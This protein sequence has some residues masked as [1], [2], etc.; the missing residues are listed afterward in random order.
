VFC[1]FAQMVV[2]GSDFDPGVGHADQRSLEIVI[3]EA[4]G[5]QHGARSSAIRPVD[6]G[7]A[8]RFEL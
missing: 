6:E 7:M 5:A 2:A 3:F 1:Q 8:S 4:A